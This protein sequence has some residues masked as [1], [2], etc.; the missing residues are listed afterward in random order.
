MA[1]KVAIEDFPQAADPF[2]RELLAHCYRMLG[3]VHDAEDLVQE[4]YLRAWKAYDRFEGRSSLRTWLH[5]IATRACLTALESRGKRPLPTGLGAPAANP[6]EQVVADGEVP[7]LEPMPDSMMGGA[8]GGDSTD[9]ASIV[10]SR[11]SIRL[12]FI[13]ALQYLPPKQRAVLILRDVLKW[14]AAEVAELLDTSTASVNSALQRAHAQIAKMAPQEDAVNEP[15]DAAQREVL[16]KWVDAFER[17]DVKLLTQLFTED[18][19]WEMP[20]FP[21]WYQG[22]EAIGTLIEYQCPAGPG[23]MRLRVSSANGQLAFGLYLRNKGETGEFRPWQYQVLELDEAGLVTHCAAFFDA[24][25]FTD[26]GLPA[27]LPADE[28]VQ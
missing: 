16:N 17:K 7:W 1:E 21:G 12:A 9:P 4:T 11:E 19:V 3:S 20:P 6:S 15:T 14:K 2:R 26:A 13:A 5:T 24:R 23:D 22:P 10:G 25:L 28:P 18:A 27:T 8:G